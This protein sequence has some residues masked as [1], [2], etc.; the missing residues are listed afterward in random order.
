MS[1][2]HSTIKMSFPMNFRRSIIALGACAL[3]ASSARAQEDA[4]PDNQPMLVQRSGRAVPLT[5]V[6]LQANGFVLTTSTGGLT[7]GQLIPLEAV[8][9]V[10]GEKPEALSRGTALL[11]MGR[12]GDAIKVMEPALAAIK[13]TAKVSG[14][15][16]VEGARVLVL[17]YALENQGPKA[18]ALAKEI[19]DAT[20]AAGS[21]PIGR[22]AKA[23]AMRPSSGAKARVAAL[24]EQIMDSNPAEI[25]AF[26]SYF[27]GRVLA[28]DKKRADA[29]TAFLSVG[30]L[31]PSGGVIVTGAAELQAGIL[32]TE[33][34]EPDTDL[35]T[36][37]R[38]QAVAL[39]KSAAI[40]AKDTLIAQEA[41]KKTESF[42]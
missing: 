15:Y 26:A 27:K 39:F 42:K 1:D 16:W 31:Y 4:E 37:N 9:H 30:C 38:N 8:S 24:D 2:T 32:F 17:A 34:N 21:D 6:A 40:D 41:L 7:Q 28:E 13:L 23:V 18:D 22:L 10:S 33:R 25:N 20:P 11:L 35:A 3:M 19:S 29:L 12:P 36:M 14:N 5:A